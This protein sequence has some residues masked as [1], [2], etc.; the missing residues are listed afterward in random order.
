MQVTTEASAMEG[1]RKRGLARG[2]A[3]ALV[4]LVA[5][6]GMVTKPWDTR[7]NGPFEISQ[8]FTTALQERDA[9]TLERLADPNSPDP[10]SLAQRVLAQLPP[11]ELSLV[12]AEYQ[13]A[14]STFIGD[15]I[16][17]LTG[18]GTSQ[19]IRVGLVGQTDQV[20]NDL[21]DWVVIYD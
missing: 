15:F 16:V 4:V 20:G 17:T 14:V 8:A 21:H 18:S 12:R 9:A 19:T 10:A 5:I 7:Y 1:F 2:V 11:G 3:G 6:A 13:T